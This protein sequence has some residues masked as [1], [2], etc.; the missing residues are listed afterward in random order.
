MCLL[1]IRLKL[2]RSFAD[3]QDA[4][5]GSSR[6]TVSDSLAIRTL[7]FVSFS[8]GQGAGYDILALLMQ[9]NPNPVH[10]PLHH[11]TLHNILR[12]RVKRTTSSDTLTIPH[13]PVDTLTVITAYQ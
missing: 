2:W 10:C 5:P 8:V 9:P 11:R 6:A 3:V 4:S 1:S 13:I 7:Q 12:R